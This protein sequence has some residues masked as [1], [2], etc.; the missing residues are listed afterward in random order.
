[1]E[2]KHLIP[3][4]GFLLMIWIINFTLDKCSYKS[5]RFPEMIK[6]KVGDTLNIGYKGKRR[7]NNDLYVYQLKTSNSITLLSLKDFN[8]CKGSKWK[9][10]LYLAITLALVIL[11]RFGSRFL[12]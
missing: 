7:K 2:G 9:I 8:S 4:Y 12:N 6:L 5:L 1:M 11:Y 10:G 3:T